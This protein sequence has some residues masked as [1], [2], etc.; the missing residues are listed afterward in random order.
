MRRKTKI[1]ATVGPATHS[2]PAI[3][4]LYEAGMS[5][6]RLNM[7]HATHDEAASVI[8]W[9][10]TLNRKVRYPV[11]VMLDTQGPEIRT[12]A[13]DE[14]LRLLAGQEVFIDVGAQTPGNG[15][16]EGS[17]GRHHGGL[18]RAPGRRACRRPCA[19]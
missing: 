17:E 7:S 10:K 14:P 8:G 19:A 15:T 5:V 2:Y 6:L 9:V 18:R 12:G 13:L 3:E 16:G 11:P 4:S 1:I